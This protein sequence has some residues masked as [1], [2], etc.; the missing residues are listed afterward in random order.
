MESHCWL[1]GPALQ[2]STHSK[3]GAP[4]DASSHRGTKLVQPPRTPELA[5]TA[6][7][8]TLFATESL[9]EDAQ[10]AAFQQ[11]SSGT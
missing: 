10:Q 11:V 9:L 4:A 6:H 3:Q 2:L 7:S 1:L 8:A 5:P